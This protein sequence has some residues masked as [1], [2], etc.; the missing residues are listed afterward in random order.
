MSH[1]VFISYRNKALGNAVVRELHR[2]LENDHDCKVFWDKRN[3]HAGD[4]WSEKIYEA[5]CESDVLIVVMEANV[6]ES[7][8]VQREVDIA[9]GAHVRILPLHIDG[10]DV[11][12]VAD[13]L[14]LEEMQR[15]TYT[16][17]HPRL[18]EIWGEIQRLAPSTRDKQ[19]EFIKALKGKWDNRPIAPKVARKSTNRAT[20]QYGDHKTRLRLVS[21]DIT[22][23]KNIDVI[24]NTENDYLQMARVYEAHTVSSRLRYYGSQIE[25]PSKRLL[26]DTVQMELDAYAAYTGRGRPIGPA[27]VVVTTSGHPQSRLAE[28]G[29]RYIFHAITVAVEHEFQERMQAIDNDGITTCV[30][31]TLQAV[32]QVNEQH[33]VISP[34]KLEF[35][36]GVDIR[37]PYKE[38]LQQTGNY[39]PITSIIFPLF[40]AG[41]AGRPTGQIIQPMLTGF[42]DFLEQT[43]NTSLTEI[44]LCAYFEHDVATVEK[45]MADN[46]ER[47]SR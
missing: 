18:D 8:W 30:I 23:F 7:H 22:S 29:I 17:D 12:A 13:R 20:F 5:I 9:H 15:L 32:E 45:A 44:H 37:T 21:G 10:E 43:P 28:R 31:N 36:D 38:Q 41:Q 25:S 11:E 14:G 1:N 42:R 34:E 16:A 47:V 33:G 4:N 3:L 35:N 24:V 39:Q 40:C 2:Y 26:E 46:F 27:Q 19:K 6:L